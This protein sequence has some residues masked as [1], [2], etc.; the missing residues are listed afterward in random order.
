M[1]K[2]RSLVRP[3]VTISG[4]LVICYLAVTTNG[5]V[6]LFLLGS[7]T[8]IIGYWFGERKK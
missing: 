1:E 2:F 5:D 3:I 7:L 4:W 6:R 8:S